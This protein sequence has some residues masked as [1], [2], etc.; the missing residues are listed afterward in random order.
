MQRGSNRYNLTY[1]AYTA[2]VGAMG[3][4]LLAFYTG[5]RDVFDAAFSWH[6]FLALTFLGLGSKFLSFKL[7]G[8]VDLTMD[9]AIYIAA[10]LVL[11]PVPAAWAAFL[12]GAIHI[13]AETVMREIRPGGEPRPLPEN[14]LFPIF[15]GGSGALAILLP[16]LV[17]PLEAYASGGL[18]TSV[19][20]L[21]LAPSLAA[22]FLLTQYTLVIQ[23]RGVD[24]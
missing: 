2:S 16:S 5:S 18:D 24:G 19:D 21:W 14:V 9:T 7:M 8:L 6:V 15:Q 13:L 20:V 10:A 23:K 17:L 3:L 4:G 1:Y 22:L 12:S 11:G